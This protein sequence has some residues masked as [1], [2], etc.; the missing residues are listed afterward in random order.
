MSCA[1]KVALY[2][3]KTP[4]RIQIV[5]TVLKPLAVSGSSRVDAE[6][7]DG[8]EHL[9]AKSILCPLSQPLHVNGHEPFSWAA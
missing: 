5:L 8:P 7:S 2:F 4:F 9:P 3:Q 1:V 6:N